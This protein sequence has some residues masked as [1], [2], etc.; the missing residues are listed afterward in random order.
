MD[1][2]STHKENLNS[3]RSDIETYIRTL[4]ELII[5]G[6]I[7]LPIPLDKYSRWGHKVSKEISQLPIPYASFLN[8]WF[9]EI[10][11][12]IQEGEMLLQAGLYRCTNPDFRTMA[13]MGYFEYKEI[14]NPEEDEY[15]SPYKEDHFLYYLTQKAWDLL[16][17]PIDSPN[18]FISYRRKESSAFAV[19]IEARLRYLGVDPTKIFIDK[20]IKSGDGWDKAIKKAIKESDY[21]IL[22]IGPETFT[23]DD[24]GINWVR[25]EFDL[26]RSDNPECKVIPICHNGQ[27]FNSKVTEVIGRIQGRAISSAKKIETKE[28]IKKEAEKESALDYETIIN[29]ILNEMGYATY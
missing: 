25:K 9:E 20:N 24:N 15:R 10:E 11:P 1:A 12:A 27:I 17:Q 13:S 7:R 22:L 19:A 3:L 2:D 5:S 4:A 23:E 8:N 28:D 26:V 14:V 21:F 6:D 16:D 18:I 29:Y